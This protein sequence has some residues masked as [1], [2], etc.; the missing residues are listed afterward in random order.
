MDRFSPHG[1]VLLADKKFDVSLNWNNHSHNTFQAVRQSLK[2]IEIQRYKQQNNVIL[3]TRFDVETAL[4]PPTFNV[5]R[6]K[7]QTKLK[8]QTNMRIWCVLF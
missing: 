5:I 3:K 4:V 8:S 1:E 7:K 6:S 2:Y